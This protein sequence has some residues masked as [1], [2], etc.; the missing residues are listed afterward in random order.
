MTQADKL[1]TAFGEI[2]VL[3]AQPADF[4][5]VMV[6]L[7]E[8]SQWLLSKGIN[9]WPA[10]AFPKTYVANSI[11]RGEFYLARRSGQAAGTIKLQWSDKMIWGDQ[12]EDAGY[13]HHLAIRRAFAG[14]QLGQQL[15]QWA[16]VRVAA[17]GK[18]YL[19]LDCWGE[20]VKL[21]QYYEHAGYLPRGEFKQEIGDRVWSIA[22]YEK[23]LLKNED[24]PALGG[25]SSA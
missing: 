22:L 10:G 2:E 13:V 8:A 20:N 1:L 18:Q 5:D 17:A 3:Q 21:K 24:L 19:R 14:Y 23:E 6:I 16:E 11:E 12:P 15:L 9:Q 4:E 7:E 25:G